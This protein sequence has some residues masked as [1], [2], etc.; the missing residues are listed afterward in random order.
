MEWLKPLHITCAVLS[1]SGFFV[2][3]IWMLHETSI[4]QQKW[5]RILPHIID[6]VLLLTALL[7]LYVMHMSVLEHD[8]LL[9]KIAALLVYIILGMVALKRGKTR[10]I[11]AVAWCAGLVVFLFIV[12]VA[13][14]KNPAGFLVWIF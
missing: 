5:V 12:S 3:G 4:L 7:M 14:I 2:R 13:L 6:T 9:S 1:F 8:W 11:R 10:M